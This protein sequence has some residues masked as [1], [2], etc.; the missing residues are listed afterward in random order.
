MNLT[1]QKGENMSQHR[2]VAF[3]DG[4]KI[5]AFHRRD[6]LLFWLRDKPEATYVR[7]TTK[8]EKKRIDFNDYE[9]APF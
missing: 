4:E 5:R 9:P 7:Y 1:D 3:I 8:A 6:E 2:Y